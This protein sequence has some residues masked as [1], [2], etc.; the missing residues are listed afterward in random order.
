MSARSPKQS[1]R[2]VTR[3]LTCADCAITACG[4]G[5]G[6]GT[7]G[8][9]P[10]FCLSTALEPDAR[11]HALAQYDEAATHRV[12]TAAAETEY[13]GYC[14]WPRVEETVQFARK[15]GA[16]LIGI[17]TCV[18]LI[19]ESRV[20]ARILRARGFDVIGVG[21]KIG[22]VPK[23]EAG[24]DPGCEEVGVNMCNPIL[25]AE[26]L[27]RAGTDLNVVMGL[28]VGH[29]ALFVRHSDAYATTLVTKDRVTGH[30]PVAAIH[31]AGTYYGKLKEDGWDE[32]VK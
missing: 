28:C 32:R 24:I 4:S 14:R 29:D 15:I 9:F 16:R 13:E 22:T 27:N 26:T 2:P 8:R 30:N 23:H 5:T 21:C 1:E 3:S 7:G 19:S 6:L 31:L 10:E 11:A 20:L 12:M 25:Q 18:G 17:A